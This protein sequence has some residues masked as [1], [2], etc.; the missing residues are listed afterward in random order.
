M[1]AVGKSLWVS[2]SMP[3]KCTASGDCARSRLKGA[4][5]KINLS[6]VDLIVEGC[7]VANVNAVNVRT[8]QAIWSSILSSDQ[9]REGRDIG[10]L[11]V[12]SFA[13]KVQA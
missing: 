11:L 8:K 5:K 6:K 12:I 10:S 2:T 3:E 13:D 9:V 4:A 7:R 1:E